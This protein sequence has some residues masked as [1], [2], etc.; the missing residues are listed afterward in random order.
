[1]MHSLSNRKFINFILLFAFGIFVFP[2]VIFAATIYF[3]SGSQNIYDG[4]T[5]IIEARIS[6]PDKLIN[7]IDGTFLFDR[8][9]DKMTVKELSTGGS[10]FPL[11]AQE[12]VFSNTDGRI[13]FVGGTPDGFQGEKGIILRIIFTAQNEG[14][15]QL[16]FDD[17]SLIFLNDGKGTKINYQQNPLTISI[18]KRP[19]GIAP[20]DEWQKIIE[21][22]KT[23]PEPFEITLGKNPALFDNQYFISF[24][25]TDKESG[26]AYYE[27]KEGDYDFVRTTSPYLLKDQPL[28]GIIKVRAVDMAGNERI[29]EFAP[30]VPVVVPPMPFYKTVIFWIITFFVLIAIGVILKLKISAKGGSASGGKYQKSK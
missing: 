25:A 6:S 3:S 2:K 1:M 20:K 8:D 26:V 5:F 24:F 30:T 7:V 9:N 12:P 10:I 16:A 29:V 18:L 23:P 28:K 11:W 14:K 15:A 4:D 22:D 13:S 19:P 21:E 17:K 27:V